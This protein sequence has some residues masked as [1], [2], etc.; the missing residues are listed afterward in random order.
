MSS[1][2]AAPAA[3]PPSL[4]ALAEALHHA[5]SPD[6]SPSIVSVELHDTE[7]VSIGRWTP[8]S[9]LDHPLTALLGFRAPDSWNAVG[10]LGSGRARMLD[11][12]ATADGQCIRFTVL[13]QRDGT[14]VSLLDELGATAPT[15]TEDPPHGWSADVLARVLGLP[16]PPPEASPALLVEAQW[17][18]R[19]AAGVLDRPGRVRSWRWLAD[20]H[21]LRGP[22]PVPDP[23][24]LAAA[25]AAHAE[26][27]PWRRLRQAAA[28]VP[29][30]AA[31]HGPSGGTV[32]DAERWF[33]DGSISRW[34]LQ[35]LGPVELVL[36]DLLDALPHHLGAS[37]SRA[38]VGVSPPGS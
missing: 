20:R 5:G 17:L 10:L 14:S 9:D 27:H 15:V 13:T 6:A 12:P 37:L 38:L 24:E 23:D 11:G 36:A 32:L 16:T 2:P 4:R 25:T 19:V 8:P 26:D 28:K 34:M 33:D 29:L 30:P 22:G 35:R 1:S 7:E 18:E 31:T 3:S 21:P